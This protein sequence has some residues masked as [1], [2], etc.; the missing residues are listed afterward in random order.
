MRV[1]LG[2]G[3]NTIR[4]KSDNKGP[5]IDRISINPVPTDC[6]GEYLPEKAHKTKAKY[7]VKESTPFFQFKNKKASEFWFEVYS[8]AEGWHSTDFSMSLKR[9]GKNAAPV[10]IQVYVGQI[11]QNSTLSLS[12]STAKNLW[13]AIS[14]DMYLEEGKN[15]IKLAGS[16]TSKRKVK[17]AGLSIDATTSRDRKY[18]TLHTVV[19]RNGG[20]VK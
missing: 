17:V 8:C 7:K 11:L 10:I 3:S 4:I 18:C 16:T 15:I 2:T 1:T 6:V 12:S 20:H 14:T 13:Q 9:K 5:E 19:L